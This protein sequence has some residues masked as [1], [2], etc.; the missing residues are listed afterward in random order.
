MRTLKITLKFRIVLFQKTFIE[1]EALFVVQLYVSILSEIQRET[2]RFL[3]K[4]AII[5]T[6]I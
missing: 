1:V 4:V 6:P 2:S 5:Q 3:E